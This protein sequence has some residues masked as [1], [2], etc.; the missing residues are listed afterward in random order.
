MS[1]AGIVF[2]LI[3]LAAALAY[4]PLSHR[5]SGFGRSVLKTVPLACFAMAAIL[6][7]APPFL[8][9]ALLLSALGDAALSRPGRGAFLYGLAA[10]ALA[11]IVYALLFTS[12][13]GQPLWAAFAL[14][15]VVAVPMLALAV[16][17]EVWLAPHTG[18]LY[19]PVRLYIV[20]ITTMMLAA[21]TLP[22]PFGLATLGAAGFV[23]S[24]MILSVQL[25][26]LDKAA[27][28]YRPLGWAVWGLYVVGQG[29]IVWGV[30]GFAG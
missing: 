26:R 2:L 1:G 5:D 14:A 15:P 18:A 27:A 21:L 9:A 7:G 12:L 11:H 22:A 25:F 19:W 8:G 23:A 17:T 4:F 13:S 20:L 29:L 6:S 16:S 30:T 28:L 3:G 10:F 24:D